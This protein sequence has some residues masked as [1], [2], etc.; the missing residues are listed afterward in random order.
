MARKVYFSFHYR[1]DIRRVV[2]VRNSWVIRS[3]RETQPFLD[4][5]EWETIKRRGKEAVARWVEKQLDGTSVTVVLIGAETHKR[6]W[7]NHEIKRSHELGKGL[8]GIH[9]HKVKDPQHG[10]DTKGPNPFDGWYFERGG[11]KVLFSSLYKT[12]DWVRDNGYDNFADWIEE[13][14]TAA[15]R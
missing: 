10:T 13:A 12:Y 6:Q 11:R 5:A 15:G 7:V 4:K 8:L 9:I 3:R 2:Q 1:Q 14:A